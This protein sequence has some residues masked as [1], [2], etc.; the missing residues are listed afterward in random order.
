MNLAQVYAEGYEY[1]PVAMRRFAAVEYKAKRKYRGPSK[2]NQPI[3]R[4]PLQKEL[5]RVLKKSIAP[6]DV[7]NIY[8]RLPESVK[9]GNYK[10]S[11]NVFLW[12]WANRGWLHAQG[13]RPH[14]VY[15]IEG[16]TCP[17]L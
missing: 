9:V 13:A 3:M 14:T 7:K 4:V 16:Q 12:G 8:E 17:K 15:C 5:W 1:N 6:L 2:S 11:A 10:R